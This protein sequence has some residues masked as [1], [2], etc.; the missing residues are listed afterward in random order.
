MAD[1]LMKLEIVTPDHQELSC[2]AE[3]VVV[4][5]TSGE[6]GFM[7]DHAP[8]IAGLVPHVLRYVDGDKKEG[9]V[10]VGGGFVEVRDNVVSVLAPS[11][12]LPQEVD[13]D[14]ARKAEER[15]QKRLAE[16]SPDIDVAR[17]QAALARATARLQLEHYL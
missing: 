13:F 10:A 16:K 6:V 17:A 4:K 12:E 5:T 2:E 14:R 11:A 15:A 9:H 7:A 8:L 1:K 3:S